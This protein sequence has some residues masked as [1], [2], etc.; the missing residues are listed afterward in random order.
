MNKEPVNLLKEYII[1]HLAVTFHK[2]RAKASAVFKALKA[3]ITIDQFVVLKLMS[4]LDSIGQQE[5]AQ[6]LGKNKSNFSRMVDVLDEKKYLI[7]K[8]SIKDNRAVKKL[9]IS[10]KGREMVKSFDGLAIALQQKAFEGISKEEIDALKSTL[11]KV[12][13]NLD[14]DIEVELR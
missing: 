5:L 11:V 10:E 4:K 8:L 13:N 1:P 6:M 7:R 12:R 9:Y 14:K 3:D 2:Y